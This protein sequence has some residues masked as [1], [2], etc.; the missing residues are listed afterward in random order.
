[1]EKDGKWQE[2]FKIEGKIFVLT[3]YYG[4]ETEMENYIESHG[5][6]IKSSTVLATDYL[7]YD[8]YEGKGTRKYNRALELIEKGKNIKMIPGK[9]FR[10]IMTGIE[11]EIKEARQLEEIV[12]NKSVTAADEKIIIKLIRKRI[13]QE[14]RP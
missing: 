13:S 12:S 11:C 3:G 4:L 10:K 1:M 14:K 5:G 8:E 9:E 2:D 7:I 6:I